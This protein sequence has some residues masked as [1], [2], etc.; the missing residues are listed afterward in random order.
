MS[1]K[2]QAH[3]N[4]YGFPATA[5]INL[6][7]IILWRHLAVSSGFIWLKWA[8]LIHSLLSCHW[9]VSV[10]DFPCS[11]YFIPFIYPSPALTT[12]VQSYTRQLPIGAGHCPWGGHTD[13]N[14]CNIHVEVDQKSGPLA[15]AGEV[16]TH[17][18]KA[19][20]YIRIIDRGAMQLV[21]QNNTLRKKSWY[22]ALTMYD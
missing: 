12:F 3:G 2:L 5:V 22:D 8:P 7:K 1:S 6:M 19:R 18:R 11:A 16:K 14:E 15:A 4:C 17:K 21:R 20:K 10:T 13:W 9:Q